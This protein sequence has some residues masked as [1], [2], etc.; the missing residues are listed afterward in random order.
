[1]ST[2]DF[3][4]K[5]QDNGDGWCYKFGFHGESDEEAFCKM[6]KFLIDEG[7]G[8]I[9]IP[10]TAR[11][12]CWDYFKPDVNDNIG[13]YVWHPIIINQDAYQVHGFNLTIFDESH[14]DHMALW[15]GTYSRK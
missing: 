3:F 7:F 1:M 9:P 15:E 13:S 12:L 2:E 10:P 8:D 11:R 4:K 6:K 5:Y 14:P